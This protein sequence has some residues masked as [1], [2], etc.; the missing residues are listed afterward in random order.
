MPRTGP[1][2]LLMLL[3]LAVAASAAQT[4][5]T[6]TDL[7][8]GAATYSSTCATCHGDDGAG[9]PGIDFGHGVFRRATTDD[10][11]FRVLREG[12]S[13]TAMPKFQMSEG[14]MRS[15]LLYLRSLSETAANSSVAGDP[16]RGKS[17]LEGKGA[18]LTCHRLANTGSRLGPSLDE[19]GRRRTAAFLEQSLLE[20]DA[21][22]LSD[23]WFVNATTRD[24]V[25]ITGR[26]M[27]EDRNTVQFIDPTGRLVSLVKRE[28][29]EYNVVRASQMPSY[30]DKLSPDELRDVVKYLTTLRGREAIGADADAVAATQDS[31]RQH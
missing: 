7:E 19:I 3:T 17:I 15:L 5:A 12:V 29:R 23:Y 24:G 13:G 25:R 20:P 27:N 18:C 9:V 6:L 2:S 11:F 22:V 21:V 1:V 4:N 8:Q 26:R 31:T 30:K 10:A 14:R 16:A 28:L